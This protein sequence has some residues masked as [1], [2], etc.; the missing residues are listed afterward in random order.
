MKVGLT[1]QPGQRVDG[2]AAASL[3]DQSLGD[4][5]LDVAED[6]RQAADRAGKG[7]ELAFGY[8]PSQGLDQERLQR[9]EV[10][11]DLERRLARGEARS[12]R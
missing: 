8:L 11:R 10:T 4:L 9:R 12:A 2:G 1:R 7:A 5:R 3:A 6:L